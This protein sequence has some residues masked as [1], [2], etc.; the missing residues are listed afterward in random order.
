M[1]ALTVVGNER[2]VPFVSAVETPRLRWLV[3]KMHRCG[4]SDW[5]TFWVHVRRPNMR[6]S[7]AI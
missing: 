4:N 5:T 2:G 1:P 6:I 3:L 7:R